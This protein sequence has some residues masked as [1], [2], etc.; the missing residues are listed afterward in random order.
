MASVAGLALSAPLALPGFQSVYQSTRSGAEAVKPREPHD[1]M[2]FI[3][4][5]FDGLPIAGSHAFG[6][7]LFYDLRQRHMLEL[8]LWCWLRWR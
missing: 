3:A 6:L 4:Q 2:Y 5:G 8:S 7:S 1:L